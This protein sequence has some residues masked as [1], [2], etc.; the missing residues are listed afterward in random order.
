MKNCGTE[1]ELSKGS[2]SVG[3]GL[4]SLPT[5]LTASGGFSNRKFTQFYGGKILKDADF[6][7]KNI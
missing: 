6:E 5:L 4:V 7:K 1:I 3:Y 2:T